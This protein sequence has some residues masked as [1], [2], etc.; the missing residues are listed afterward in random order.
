[1]AVRTVK[2]AADTASAPGITA[3]RA[4]RRADSNKKECTTARR[5]CHRNVASET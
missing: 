2:Q 5:R 1:M 3:E 4:Y